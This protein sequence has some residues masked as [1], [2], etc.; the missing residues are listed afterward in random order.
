MIY[1]LVSY[2]EE[3]L[4]LLGLTSSLAVTPKGTG[5]TRYKHLPVPPGKIFFP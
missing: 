5:T 4:T 2:N 3:P 1:P